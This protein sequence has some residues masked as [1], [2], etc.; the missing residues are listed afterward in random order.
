MI[1]RQL[2]GPCLDLTD[3]VSVA[4]LVSR[5]VGGPARLWSPEPSNGS[6]SGWSRVAE[7]AWSFRALFA[8]SWEGDEPT[9][10]ILAGELLYSGVAATEEALVEKLIE[11]QA[12]DRRCLKR[13]VRDLALVTDTDME[14]DRF[15]RQRLRGQ[16][17]L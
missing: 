7:P 16:A 17:E 5:V 10:R 9:A 2:A 15:L 8:A 3:L 12:A 14:V 6:I 13:R 4:I 11:L 1:M